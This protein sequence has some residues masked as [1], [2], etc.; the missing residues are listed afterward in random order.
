MLPRPKSIFDDGGVAIGGLA[1]SAP[2][3]SFK[4]LEDDMVAALPN[5]RLRVVGIA[6]G[7]YRNMEY[8]V[9]MRGTK[10]PQQDAV[11]DKVVA[12][13]TDL[14]R[15]KNRALL[16]APAQDQSTLAFVNGGRVGPYTVSGVRLEGEIAGNNTAE[17]PLEKRVFVNGERCFPIVTEYR[18]DRWPDAFF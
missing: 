18:W 14:D 8:P 13:A 1:W 5:G 12:I 15:I 16:A 3:P 4:F 6:V 9:I 2:A 17:A 11:V 7:G 10:N